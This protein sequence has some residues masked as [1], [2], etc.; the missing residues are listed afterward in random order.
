MA[1]NRFNI[2]VFI[3]ILLIAGV[4]LLLALTIQKDFSQMTSAVL[5]II[6]IGQILFLA[7]YMNRIHRD[8]DRFME[9]LKNKDTTQHFIGQREASTSGVCITRL[10]RSTGIS[11]LSE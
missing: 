10:R 9:G 11:G 8:V 7:H 5:T 6:S 2:V 4:S 3:Q 1:L